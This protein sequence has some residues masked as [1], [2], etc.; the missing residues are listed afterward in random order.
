M[1]WQE[2]MDKAWNTVHENG[3]RM[4]VSGYRDTRSGRWQYI[5]VRAGRNRP[6]YARR[7]AVG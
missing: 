3:W 4:R 1:T 7:R 5:T 2:A 6:T